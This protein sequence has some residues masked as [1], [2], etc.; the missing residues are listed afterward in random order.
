VLAWISPWLDHVTP[1]EDTCTCQYTRF[2][3]IAGIVILQPVVHAVPLVVSLS[4]LYG[5]PFVLQASAR[6]LQ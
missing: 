1:S 4:K 5:D 2:G 6:P 3:A